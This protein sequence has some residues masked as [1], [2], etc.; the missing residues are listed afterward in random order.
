MIVAEDADVALAVRTPEAR[1]AAVLHDILE[2]TDVTEAQLQEMGFDQNVIVAVQALTKRKGETRLEA[3]K[4]AKVNP[5][6]REVKIEDNADNLD[7]SRLDDLTEK[8]LLRVREYV[9]VRKVL[10]AD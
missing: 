2:D 4:R 6:A 3:A 5:I 7:L 8:D 1:I 9:L 10:R